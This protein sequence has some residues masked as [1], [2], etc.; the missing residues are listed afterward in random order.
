MCNRLK[1]ATSNALP[2]VSVC[3]CCGRQVFQLTQHLPTGSQ[4]AARRNNQY[5]RGTSNLRVLCA[6]ATPGANEFDNKKKNDT[7]D[8]TSC[9]QDR[10]TGTL[11][12]K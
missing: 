10:L 7:S 2:V 11:N 3:N 12:E 4:K 6:I 5:S 8:L 1:E 9:R